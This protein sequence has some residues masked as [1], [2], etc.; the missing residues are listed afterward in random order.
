[1]KMLIVGDPHLGKGSNL[2]KSIGQLNSRFID[3]MNLLEWALEQAVSTN[4]NIICLTGDVFDDPKPHHNIVTQ[5]MSWLKKCQSQDI[6]VHIVVGNHDIL[7]HGNFYYSALDIIDEAELDNI[8][9]HKQYDTILFDELETSITFMPFRDRKSFNEESSKEALSK[10]KEIIDYECYSSPN[11]YTKL[12]I[13]H[14]ALEGSVPIGNEIDDLINELFCPIEYF[15]SF[16]YTWLGHIHKPQVLSNTPY[17]AHIGSMDISD[18][19]EATHKKY[20]VIYDFEEKSFSEVLIP[21]RALQ[22]IDIC[23]PDTCEDATAYVLSKLEEESIKD[24][25]ISLNI[26]VSNSSIK[27]A[28]RQLIQQKLLESGVHSVSKISEARKVHVA[29]KTNGFNALNISSYKLD[30]P[31]AIKLYAEQQIDPAERAEFI[32]SAIEIYKEYQ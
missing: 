24:S 10:L 4:S 8:H 22:K 28:N 15:S 18:F 2:G 31:E 13:G 17:I 23:I 11:N 29:K 20:I 25:I 26:E 32:S 1:M 9:I 5:F 12:A 6:S 7:R 16:N 3:Q 27:P 19:G 14:L 21:T 30:V